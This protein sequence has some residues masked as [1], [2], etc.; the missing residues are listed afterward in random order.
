M[1]IGTLSSVAHKMWLLSLLGFTGFS[2]II[3]RM[4]FPQCLLCRAYILL[5]DESIFRLSGLTTEMEVQN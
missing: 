3:S 1:F 2:L 5:I 4:V